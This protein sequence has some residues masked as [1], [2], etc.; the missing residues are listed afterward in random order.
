MA[1]IRAA[2]AEAEKKAL[3][4]LHDVKNAPTDRPGGRCTVAGLQPECNG[5]NSATGAA[6]RPRTEYPRSPRKAVCMNL[7]HWAAL[8]L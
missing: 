1:A 2:Q 4:P 7:E 3:P 8:Y 6:M 5:R